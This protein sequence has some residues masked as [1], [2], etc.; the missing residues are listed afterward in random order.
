MG[1][2]APIPSVATVLTEPPI[3][4]ARGQLP[5][6]IM[7]GV[8]SLACRGPA[9]VGLD[10]GPG[11]QAC[12]SRYVARSALGCCV[13]SASA[14]HARYAGASADSVGDSDCNTTFCCWCWCCDCPQGQPGVDSACCCML[15]ST[16]SPG[17]R[18]RGDEGEEGPVAEGLP[19]PPAHGIKSAPEPD[20][21]VMC[22]CSMHSACQRV[23]RVRTTVLSRPGARR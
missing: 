6:L 14:R 20:S 18:V 12:V 13:F 17:P 2:C 22:A 16:L 8:A 4:D 10:A 23:R 15:T 19:G 3:R 1:P 7:L 5:S 9:V 21:T 11:P